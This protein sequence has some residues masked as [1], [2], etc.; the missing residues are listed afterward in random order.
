MDRP[1]LKRRKLAKAFAKSVKMSVDDC[2]WA[3]ELA[4]D[5]PDRAAVL[6]LEW[7]A[8]GVPQRPKD[9]GAEQAPQKAPD[10]A[11]EAPARAAGSSGAVAA[12]QQQPGASEQSPSDAG[13]PLLQGSQSLQGA[14]S[15]GAEALSVLPDNSKP[16]STLGITAA[17]VHHLLRQLATAGS[18]LLADADACA[19]AL[20]DLGAEAIVVGDD[21]CA[22][23]SRPEGDPSRPLSKGECAS[24]LATL[25]EACAAA[26]PQV[27]RLSHALFGTGAIWDAAESSGAG[28]ALRTGLAAAAVVAHLCRVL[29]VPADIRSDKAPAA[30]AALVV[31]TLRGLSLPAAH[32]SAQQPA[33][34][35]AEAPDGV[36]PAIQPPPKA[37]VAHALPRAGIF[38]ARLA[39]AVR[40]LAR[41]IAGP[42]V[43]LDAGEA[44]A[45]VCCEVV[46]T[47][48]AGIGR[49]RSREAGL[50][51]SLALHETLQHAAIEGPAAVFRRWPAAQRG[52]V[53]DAL[54]AARSASQ[55]S[56]RGRSRH[57]S[58]ASYVV[59]TAHVAGQGRLPASAEDAATASLSAVR[60]GAAPLATAPS[61]LL[62]RLVAEAAVAAVDHPTAGHAASSSSSVAAA[63]LRG[64][65]TAAAATASSIAT[66]LVTRAAVKPAARTKRTRDATAAAAAEAAAAAAAAPE[67]RRAIEVLASDAAA[68]AGNPMGLG[69][70]LLLEALAACA[71][72][73]AGGVAGPSDAATRQSV[74]ALPAVASAIGFA[75]DVAAV[76]RAQGGALSSDDSAS[77]RGWNQSAGRGRARAA[78]ES[79]KH[80]F[81]ASS[82]ATNAD[83]APDRPRNPVLAALEM[84]ETAAVAA[85]DRHRHIPS[86]AP[87][88]SSTNAAFLLSPARRELF[89]KFR[90]GLRHWLGY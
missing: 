80:G 38:A 11:P 4:A 58:M 26:R 24:L 29:R 51:A 34:Q 67:W 30:A 1:A 59:T 2:T 63:K 50:A 44:L 84:V 49:G 71:V 86:L 70:A 87:A 37:R 20:Q 72:K 68:A 89:G 48:P 16:V 62:F 39:A 64:A 40:S 85:A 82:D 9:T 88:A 52:V 17:G 28:A 74:V 83:D 73:A 14:D 46:G 13:E 27:V 45:A 42:L 41:G 69:S 55:G 7:G 79:A 75:A 90:H 53:D 43:P 10:A 33:H 5:D 22:G 8:S 31:A 60:L 23:S 25:A 54:S 61:L 12:A 35:D 47:S 21:D 36:H 6:L 32:G 18:V 77:L 65:A 57:A 78:L 15:P 66:A 76:R 81:S 19:A 3:L 56:P